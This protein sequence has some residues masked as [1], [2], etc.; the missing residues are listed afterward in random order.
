M[1]A[2]PIF[3][4][5]A[6]IT[7]S[8]NVQSADNILPMSRHLR[9]TSA[10]LNKKGSPP[11]SIATTVRPSS[12]SPLSPQG[13]EATPT[14]V[15]RRPIEETPKPSFLNSLRKTFNAII[16]NFIDPAAH[17]PSV[18]P[19][20]VLAHN[21][22]PVGELPPTPSPVVRGRIPLALR[23]GAYVR[24]G[25]NPQHLPGGTHHIFDGDGML[26]CLHLSA[27]SDDTAPATFCS[28]YVQTCRYLLE[29]EAGR[30][31]LPNIFSGMNGV[32]GLVRRAAVVARV[33]TGKMDLSAAIGLANIALGY[34]GGRLFA[35]GEA[36]LPYAIHLSPS[37]DVITIGRWDFGGKLSMG[38]TAHPKK[39]PI[40]GEVF[41]FRCGPVPPFVTYF[42]FD[43][44]GKKQPDVP[45]FSVRHPSYLHDFAITEKYAIFCD[46]QI[47]METLQ[48][49]LGSGFPFGT[50][51]RKVPRVGILPRYAASDSD[52]RWFDVPGFNPVHTINAWEDDGGDTVVLVAPNVLSLEH[53]LD[54]M[55]LVHCCVEMVRIDLRTGAVSRTPLSAG[56]LDFGV[57]NPCYLGRRNRYA[58]LGVGSPQPMV[59][60][61]MKLDM[62]KKGVDCVT[63]SRM[64]GPRRFGGEPIFVPAPDEGEEEDDGYLVTYLHDENTGESSF[65]VMDARSPDLQVVAEVSLPR[66]VPYGFHGLFITAAEL[67]AQKGKP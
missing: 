66:R 52:I 62:V 48:M 21:W 32:N 31:V 58:Y 47:V 33:I 36:D 30:N 1:D 6:A 44:E 54:R 39:D 26:H 49:V 11:E 25:P 42:R 13:K 55:E 65:L 17:R 29:R 53:A 67:R 19:R 23:G 2:L 51:A 7:S 50:D 18:N 35:L 12:S 10:V 43:A 56:N 8:H 22:A 46:M 41:A 61:V 34:F 38:M 24:N 45:I 16:N 63:A 9:R 57:I 59:A 27:G 60:G 14:D 28:R 37:G 3:L 20:Y 15:L 4:S 40:T 5:T 64:Y